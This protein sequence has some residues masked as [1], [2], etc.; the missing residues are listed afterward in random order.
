MKLDRSPLSLSSFLIRAHD[1]FWVIA[2]WY[3]LFVIEP[4]AGISGWITAFCIIGAFLLAFEISG[5]YRGMWRFASLPDLVNILKA[6]ALGSLLWMA[7][8]AI[9][10]VMPSRVVFALYPIAL[11]TLLA[12]PRFLYRQWRSQRALES[13][14][15]PHRVLVVGAGQRTENFLRQ[16]LTAEGLGIVGVLDDRK[17][18]QGMSLYNARVIGRIAELPKIATETAASMVVVDAEEL[19]SQDLQRLVHECEEL[20][21]RFKR[22][23]SLDQIIDPSDGL[24]LKDLEIEDLLGR[25]PVR[26]DPLEVR[27]VMFG[28]NV[29][30][31]GAGGSIGSEIC[32]K[33]AEAGVAEL[34]MIDSAE[35]PLYVI[36][37][38]LH[39]RHPGLQLVPLLGHCASESLLQRAFSRHVDFVFHAAAYKQVPMLEHQ[40][41]AAIENNVITSY[42]VAAACVDAGVADFVLISTDKAVEPVNV[43]G[44]TKRMAERCCLDATRGTETRCSVIRFGNVLDSVGSVVPLFRE[45]I[46]RG[47]P[48]TVT[49]PEVTRFFMTIPE[50]CKLILHAMTLDKRD[51]RLFSLD[52]GEPVRILDLARQ[53]IALAGKVEGRDLRIE[54]IG[55]RAGEKLHEKLFHPGEVLMP[56]THPRILCSRPRP[57]G[58][59]SL[60]LIRQLQ[61]A[62][63][64]AKSEEELQQLLIQTIDDYEPGLSDAIREKTLT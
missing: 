41:H 64:S 31:T 30:V 37:N 39:A 10:G 56:T 2:L 55:L 63:R 54:F 1:G 3:A 27:R 52:M 43:L 32:R 4:I 59:D 42:R 38:E 36:V 12:G 21:L 40:V 29:V 45:Q 44:A 53:M 33:L 35:N 24:A 48:V 19:G 18:L 25:A 5:L 22:L 60:E 20:Q 9:A 11:V 16:S 49:H 13:S 23:P 62:C 7:L 28:R 34:V 8:S 14:K 47:G 51:Q 15:A 6:V 17:E 46:N 26:F 61:Q 58:R 57:D 50:A